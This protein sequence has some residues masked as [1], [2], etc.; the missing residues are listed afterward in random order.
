MNL[1]R[2]TQPPLVGESFA[3]RLFFD[4][5]IV[6]LFFYIL[7]AKRGC[8]PQRVWRQLFFLSNDNYFSR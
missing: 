2:K 7:F 3:I 5:L 1:Q 6:L 8:S 4:S